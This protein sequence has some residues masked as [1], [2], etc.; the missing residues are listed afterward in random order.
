MIAWRKAG[1]QI[2]A[3]L[4]AGPAAL[5]SRRRECGILRRGKELP[6]EFLDFARAIGIEGPEGIRVELVPFVPLP[7]PRPIVGVLRNL[8]FPILEAAGMA[9]G[10]GVAIVTDNPALLRHE[11]VHVLQYQRLGG[12]LNFMRVYLFECLFHGYF[13]APLEIEARSQIATGQRVEP[14]QE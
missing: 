8:G 7:L 6:A 1:C 11:L 9:L 3:V 14:C 12:H 4:L 10:R 2:A 13:A 5:W